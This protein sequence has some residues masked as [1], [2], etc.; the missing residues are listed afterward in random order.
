MSDD[1]SRNDD[2]NG[3][4]NGEFKVPPRT[5]IIWIAIL[6]AIPLLIIFRNSANSP[7]DHLSQS[8]FTQKV[9]SNQITKGLITYDPQSPMM[10]KITGKYI[11]TD[12]DGKPIMENGKTKEQAFHLRPS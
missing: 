8:Q 3:K 1:N 2:K 9:D 11:M 12:A 6:A 5:Y 4:K 10:V 7:G